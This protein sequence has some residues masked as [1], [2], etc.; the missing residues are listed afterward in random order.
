MRYALG[1]DAIPFHVGMGATK[2]YCKLVRRRTCSGFLDRA[3][4][5][6][7][8]HDTEMKST[9]DIS[10]MSADDLPEAFVHCYE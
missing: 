9:A 4:E 10:P 5:L 8:H 1:G 7:A 2:L 3:T 6:L